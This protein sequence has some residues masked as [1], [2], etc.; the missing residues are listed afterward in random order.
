[1]L[2]PHTGKVHFE[3]R[4]QAKCASDKE[5]FS[6]SSRWLVRAAVAHESSPLSALCGFYYYLSSDG[7]LPFINL[8][9]ILIIT[10][11]LTPTCVYCSLLLQLP[12]ATILPACLLFSTADANVAAARSRR[13]PIYLIL[14]H[15]QIL[16]HS[17]S[18]HFFQPFLWLCPSPL[19]P[20][21][22]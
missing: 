7:L 14:S 3:K 4:S 11:L 17:A 19:H 16:L 12:S 2:E 20:L 21:S 22:R 13:S 15:C 5:T 18:H 10:P 8:I 1:M 6:L 9:V